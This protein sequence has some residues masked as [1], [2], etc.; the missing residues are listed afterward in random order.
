ML[1]I[2]IEDVANRCSSPGDFRPGT[3]LS[4]RD[5]EGRVLWANDDFRNGLVDHHRALPVKS[6]DTTLHPAA[7]AER[8]RWLERS[9]SRGEPSYCYQVGVDTVLLWSCIPVYLTDVCSWAAIASCSPEPF[10]ANTFPVMRT[11]CMDR[12]A[13]LSREER[14]TVYGAL[15]GDSARAI[16][17]RGG[18]TP[19]GV[20]RCLD[21]AVKAL[22]MRTHEGLLAWGRRRHLHTLPTSVWN[23]LIALPVFTRS[24]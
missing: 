23:E 2:E 3:I 15:R 22:A 9:L 20:G 17:M 10:V 5:A 7:A 21:R 14:D 11:A 1:R 8:R 24:A 6:Y 19:E 12:L 16:A 18:C 4:L 13:T